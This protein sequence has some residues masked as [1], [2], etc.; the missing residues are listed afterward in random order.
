M[1]DISKSAI[2]E[3][4]GELGLGPFFEEIGFFYM[5]VLKK[6]MPKY[7]NEHLNIL[8]K[9]ITMEE[10]RL[11]YKRL[12]RSVKEQLPGNEDMFCLPFRTQKSALDLIHTMMFG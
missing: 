4:A 1:C 11:L 12:P 9:T 5:T 2:S 10:I 3:K 7:G 6:A 8:L